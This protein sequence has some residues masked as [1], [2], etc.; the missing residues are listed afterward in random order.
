MGF[1]LDNIISIKDFSKGDIE[2]ILNLAEEMEPI[3]K[4]EEKSSVLSGSILGMLF[5]EASTRTRLS[6]DTA[7]KRLGGNTVGFAEAGTSSATKGENLTDTVRTVGEYADA[8]VIR[9][10]M[11]G[12][13]RYVAEMVDVP[14]INAGDGAGQHPTQTLLDLYTM[15]R[16]LGDIEGLHVALI[17]DLKYG[18]TVHS[19]SYALAMFGAKMSFVSPSELKMPRETLHDL[20]AAGVSVQ[21]TEEIRD[22]LSYADVLYVTRIQ[23]ERFP[24]AQ[25]YLKIKGAYTIDSNLLKGSEAIVMHPL[26]RVDEISHDVDNT[27]YGRYFQ[28][29]F[30]GVPVRMALLKSMIK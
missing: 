2:Y 20:A 28:Q 8:L 1:K 30:Y 13:A 18:R 25:E 3:A 12:T 27:P 22:V 24:D 21:E 16:L 23:K 29:A 14:V 15:K 7:M 9:H 19:L 11:E 26:P 17:G 6:F 4:S 10:N 5:Y